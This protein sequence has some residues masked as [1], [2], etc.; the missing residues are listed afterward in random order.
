MFLRRSGYILVAALGLACSGTGTDGGDGFGSARGSAA[1]HQW[2]Q[3]FC[4]GAKRCG[5]NAEA[6]EQAKGVYCASDAAATDCAARMQDAPCGTVPAACAPAALADPAPAR[7]DC[8]RLVSALCDRTVA[9][10]GSKTR[11]SCATETATALA[12][13]RAVAAK[14][15]LETCIDAVGALQCSATALPSMCNGAVVKN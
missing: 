5:L 10:D 15:S 12:C 14:P 3:A 9:C 1:C 7:V 8:E 4:E 13:T 2:Q 6:C 11:E